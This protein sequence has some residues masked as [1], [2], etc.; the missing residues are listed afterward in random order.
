MIL[1]LQIKVLEF[2]IPDLHTWQSWQVMKSGS[3]CM[4]ADESFGSLDL[5]VS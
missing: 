3:C 4:L 1:L 5:A 2:A